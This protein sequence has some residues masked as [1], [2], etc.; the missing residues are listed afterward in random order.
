M[1]HAFFGSGID[2]PDALDFAH[3]TRWRTTSALKRLL[4]R[5][6]KDAIGGHDARA[7]LLAALPPDLASFA[8]LARDQYVEI[9]TLLS[10]YLLS[11]QGDRML[12]ASSVEGRFPFLDADV[13]KLANALPP[14]YKLRVLDEKH[15]LKRA[16]RDLVPPEILRRKKQ[17]YRAPDALSFVG[18]SAPPW[19]RELLD[20]RA[21]ARGGVF[22]PRAVSALAGKCRAAA[23]TGKLSNFDNMAL[24]GVLS[25]QLL[26][27]GFVEQR[28]ES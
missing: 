11:A 15:V 25:T 23:A 8:P 10:G 26:H 22:D 6:M 13:V 17:P 20:E 12:M 18:A 16:S 28:R 2:A 9:K 1:S 19:V 5:A 27:H 7:E 21:V 14:S 24:V 4:S 3:D